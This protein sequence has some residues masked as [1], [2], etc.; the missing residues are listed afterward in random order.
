MERERDEPYCVCNAPPCT[1]SGCEHFD[2]PHYVCGTGY[3]ASECAP[4]SM[5]QEL[6]LMRKLKEEIRVVEA[7]E[8]GYHECW[9]PLRRTLAA[10]DKMEES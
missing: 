8:L 5:A 4:E 2:G 1:A 3:N 10:L 7:N 9:P 6:Q